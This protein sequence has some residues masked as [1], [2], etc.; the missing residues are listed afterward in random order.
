MLPATTPEKLM[1]LGDS[2]VAK[3]C[4][5]VLLSG[6]ATEDGGVSFDGFYD[7]II[8]L[9]GLGLQVIAHTGIIDEDTANK[10]HEVK[11]DQVLVDAI[12]D[13][14]TIK[15][16]YHLDK[17]PEDFD[18]WPYWPDPDDFAHR[19]YTFFK[20]VVAKYGEKICIMGMG[21]AYGLHE[22]MNWVFGME[23][24]PIWIRKRPE[25][26]K[27]YLDFAEQLMMKTS[28]AS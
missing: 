1:E 28:M 8:Y 19:T 22:T 25:Y 7:A 13:N 26:V 14:D 21:P 10:L 12:G 5:G 18:S 24:V 9:K 17:T 2:L 6:G 15:N 27:R 20:K 4:D 16:V 11:I 23:K 3:G